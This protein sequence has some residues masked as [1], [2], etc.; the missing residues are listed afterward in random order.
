ME[1][2][3][4]RSYGR[5]GTYSIEYIKFYFPP[6]ISEFYDSLEYNFEGLKYLTNKDDLIETLS[7]YFIYNELYKTN[8]YDEK[9]TEYLDE[10][11]DDYLNSVNFRSFMLYGKREFISFKDLEFHPRDYVTSVLENPSISDYYIDNKI[12]IKEDLE[13]SEINKILNQYID[14]VVDEFM[15]IIE[16]Y[17]E[18]RTKVIWEVP[19]TIYRDYSP[20]SD[21]DIF[22]SKIEP[23]VRLSKYEHEYYDYDIGF[24]VRL[25]Y[26][27][28]EHLP[29]GDRILPFDL[30]EPYENDPLGKIY[31]KFME[32]KIERNPV[33]NQIERT[34]HYQ[35]FKDSDDENNYSGNAEFFLPFPTVRGRPWCRR[36]GRYGT[37]EGRFSSTMPWGGDR[38]QCSP[39]P[40]PEGYVAPDPKDIVHRFNIRSNST[41]IDQYTYRINSFAWGATNVRTLRYRARGSTDIRNFEPP[42]TYESD[43]WYKPKHKIFGEYPS[44]ER[45]QEDWW[46]DYINENI[47]N[48]ND[49]HDFWKN[50]MT[51]NKDDFI[52]YVNNHI[53]G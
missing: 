3:K 44:L 20:I 8:D 19:H 18:N 38:I 16:F 35:T 10:V 26:K 36:G 46:E 41:R 13:K 1:K 5:F 52:W 32:R 30:D 31:N 4:S 25:F 40:R 9:I 28:V 6:N 37:V 12:K 45:R 17:I 39:I 2:V 27:V 53:R 11:F 51:I 7:S 50:R 34:Y 43:N 24:N 14:D 22:E 33:T 21:Q 47:Q 48:E 42:K 23:L 49:W 29:G 15:S